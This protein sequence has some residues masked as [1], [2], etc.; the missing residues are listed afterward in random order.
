MWRKRFAWGLVQ[1]RHL[2]HLAAEGSGDQKE[3][4]PLEVTLPGETRQDPSGRGEEKDRE[5]DQRW[6]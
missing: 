4:S 3:Q 1:K 6:L 5:Q 2:T